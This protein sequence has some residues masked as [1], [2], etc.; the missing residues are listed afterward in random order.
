MKVETDWGFCGNSYTAPNTF[1]DMQAAIN[2]Y[3]EVSA[4]P[5]SKMPSTLLGC[6]GKAPVLQLPVTSQ[7]RGAWVLP[8]GTSSIWVAGSTAYLVSMTVPATSTSIAQFSVTMIG[9][10]AT[11]SGPVCIRDNGAGGYAVIVDGPYG[12]YYRISGA[13]SFSFTGGVTNGSA[14]VTFSGSVPTGLIVGSVVSDSS[15]F[16]TGKTIT[17]IDVNAGTVTLNGLASGTNASDTITLALVQYARITDPA[18]L[19]AD[20]LDFVDGWLLFN[21]P[22]TQNI[23]TNAPVPYT[24]IFA[25][26][27]YAKKDVG[28]DNVVSHAVNNRDWWV[29]GE[30]QSEVWADSGATANF[31]FARLPGIAPQI[32][33]AAKHSLARLGDELCFLARSERGENVVVKTSQYSFESISNHAIEH[34]ISSYPLVSDAVGYTYEDE[35]HLFYVLTFPTADATWVYDATTSVKLGEPAWHQRASYDSNTGTL[36][37]DRGY[38]FVNF[39]NLRLVGDYQS[40]QIHRLSRTIYDDAGNVLLSRRRAP[41]IWSKM[42][43]KRLFYGALQIEFSPGVGRETGQ[44]D[45][46]QAILRQSN[47]GGQNYGNE[48]F[49]SIGKI[50]ETKNRAIWRRRGYARDTVFEVTVTDPVNRDIVGATLLVQSE[51]EEEAA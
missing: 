38:C 8:G 40:G 35:G 5:N 29:L 25:G 6:P 47:D 30:R 36:H 26:L 34:A 50:G 19:G 21:Q 18:F 20:R 48:L 13:G 41:H 15:G 16:I 23:Y 32:G 37:Q 7:V 1:Q 31:G 2:Y 22:G 12:Y 10:L 17:A 33:C 27:F 49:A 39:Q 28:S 46:P 11:N 51:Q 24:L 43:R 45:N 3:L 9:T 42:D 14:T 4:D 44:G